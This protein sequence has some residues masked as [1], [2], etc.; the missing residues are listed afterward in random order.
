MSPFTRADLE[1]SLARALWRGDAAAG[2]RAVSLAEDAR[3]LLA[4]H[5]PATFRYQ[6]ELHHVERWLRDPSV[7]ALPYAV[8]DPKAPEPW[9]DL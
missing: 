8:M 1:L 6:N 3:K 9:G 5:A 2:E 7:R 4:A